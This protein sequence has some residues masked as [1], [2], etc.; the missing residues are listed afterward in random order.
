MNLSK[1][2]FNNINEIGKNVKLDGKCREVYAEIEEQFGRTPL[3]PQAWIESLQGGGT[4]YS[5]GTGIS[6]NSNV[7]SIDKEQIWNIVQ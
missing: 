3:S 7:I 1:W 2:H 5:A 4:Q 6:I